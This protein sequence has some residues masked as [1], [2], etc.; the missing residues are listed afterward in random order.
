MS[1]I[2]SWG[3]FGSVMVV[4]IG[5]AYNATLKSAGL[6][7]SLKLANDEVARLRKQIDT[8]HDKKN[9]LSP[10]TGN[11]NPVNEF[12]TLYLPNKKSEIQLKR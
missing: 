6:E 5:V 8:L 9:N 1:D 12:K 7:Q 3:I 11:P 10:K 2:I 4:A